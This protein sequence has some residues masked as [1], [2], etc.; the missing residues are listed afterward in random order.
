MVGSVLGIIRLN[1][2]NI[3]EEWRQDECPRA[4]LWR[5]EA[6]GSESES[7]PKS[8]LLLFGAQR[9]VP[10]NVLLLIVLDAS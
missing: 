1:T 6:G 7:C 2:K 9:L 3:G 5:Y 10:A 4:G 8:G